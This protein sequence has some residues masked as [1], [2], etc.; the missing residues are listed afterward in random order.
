MQHEM[1][2]LQKNHIWDS[3]PQPHKKNIVK[4]QW[5]Y[6]T[7][8]TSKGVIEHHKHYLVAKCFSHK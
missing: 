3:I 4:C 7:K 2:S 1:D 5:V 8:F 6:H